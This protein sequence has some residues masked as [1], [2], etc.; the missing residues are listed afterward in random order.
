[1]AAKGEIPK[2]LLTCK[3]PRCASCCY[4]KAT[5]VPWR[6]KGKEKG[7]I[8]VATKPGECV[9]V[10]Q[11][12]SPTVGFLAQLK[13]ALT[14]KRYKV[15]TIFI[16]HYSRLSFVYLQK[17]TK[18][19]ETV[20]AKKAFERFASVYGVTVKH[21]HSDNGRFAEN[22]FA[23]A[24]L[25]GTNQ[26]SITFCGVNAHWQNGIAEKRV[27]DLQSQARTMLLHGQHRWPKMLS[28]ALWPYALR[29]AN[30]IQNSTPKMK[31]GRSPIEDFSG[32][33]VTP[34]VRHFHPFG[35]PTYVLSN[36]LQGGGGVRPS[37]WVRRSRLG[38]YLGPSSRHARSVSLI[39]NPTTGLVSPQFHVKHDDFFETVKQLAGPNETVARWKVLSGLNLDTPPSSSKTK[40][41]KTTKGKSAQATPH[42]EAEGQG[43][44]PPSEGG[45]QR[46][47]VSEGASHEPA[48]E[49]PH[50]PEIRSPATNG[51]NESQDTPANSQETDAGPRGSRRSAR[52]SVPRQRLIQSMLAFHVDHEEQEEF[53]E[54]YESTDK[55]SDPIAFTASSSPDILNFKQAM[56]ADDSKQFVHAMGEEIE[57]HTENGHWELIR[58]DDVPSGQDILP[59]VWAFR[60]KRKIATQ[61]VYKWKARLNLHGGRQT[62]GVNYWE[63]YAPV[64]NWFSIRLFLIMSLAKGW[65]TRQIDFVLAYPQADIECDLYMQIPQGFRFAGSRQTH[66]LKLKKNLYG[67]KQAGRVWNQYLTKGLIERGFTQS[68]VDECVYYRGSVIFMVYVD[69]GILCG[70]DPQEIQKVIDELQVPTEGTRA[71]KVSDEG[72]IDDYLGVKVQRIG[73]TITLTQPHLIQKILDDLGFKDNTKT[74]DTPAKVGVILRRDE[75]GK[76]FDEDWHYR[77]VI[78]KMN[79]LE[80]STRPDI[81]YATHQCARFSIDPKD[82][83]ADAIKFIGR[84]LLGTKDKGLILKTDQDQQFECYVDCDFA[85]NWHPDDAMNDPSTAKS[86]TGYVIKYA[87]CPIIWASKLQ[88]LTAL[89]T[90]ESEY[91]GLSTALREVICL[92]ELLNEARDFGIEVMATKPTIR[93]TVFEDNSGALEIARTPKMRPRTRHINNVYHHF[94]EYVKNGLIEI[95][96]VSTHDQSAD[97]FT[98]PLDFRTFIRHR[99]A[100]MHW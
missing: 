9:S 67:Q 80:K 21:Y 82:S 48:S 98:K 55:M 39:L 16:D 50:D 78:G 72:E 83:H 75:N 13:G 49:D 89:S 65:H 1:M 36:A 33:A 10:D 22:K 84:Y 6:T 71:F 42:L 28:T 90:T 30:E 18:G 41:S 59:A 73:S 4:G 69:D 34:K 29:T 58:K 2:R 43:I 26:Q 100:I 63:T 32:V 62:Y 93:C 47:P 57:A 96:A 74:K 97:I 95:L 61:E 60:R 11:L 20:L 8:R 52:L 44:I 70:P 77:S 51:G 91:I 85:G 79:F 24:L 86:R 45:P 38:I 7:H 87:G 25:E 37:K 27:Q 35:C 14:T 94:R 54:D 66:A 56:Q 23:A 76:P 88:T 15:A 31:N 99:L 81:A 19:D 46:I 12:E 17:T 92:M 5:K 53:E 68:K 3:V 40:T 64:V